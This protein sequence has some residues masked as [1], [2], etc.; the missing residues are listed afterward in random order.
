MLPGFRTPEK[1]FTL[2]MGE[3]SVKPYPSIM[4]APVFA[5]KFFIT[6]TG[7]GEPP[8]KHA[9]MDVMSALSMSGCF[10]MFIYMVGTMGTKVGL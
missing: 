8:E 2:T 1:G 3:D 7:I 6:S 10:K 4:T 5:S 9:L